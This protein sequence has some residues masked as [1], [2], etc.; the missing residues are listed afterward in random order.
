MSTSASTTATTSDS[1]SSAAA[2]AAAAAG[3]ASLLVRARTPPLKIFILVGQSNMEGH[4]Y[5]DKIDD[6][7]GNFLNGTLEWMVEA[8]P[9]T[10]GKLKKT[11]DNNNDGTISSSW[12]QRD[13]VSIAY[14]RQSVG[15]VRPELNQ[16][17]KLVPGYG[18]DPGQENHQ[19]GPELGF[20]WTLGDALD[21][22]NKIPY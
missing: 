11:N 7:N 14:N 22:E 13:D 2:A 12:K 10:Y 16:Y 17:G 21:K 18:G 19:M 5:M 4:G 1:S 15:N 8:Y 3:V 9:E 20:G 6:D